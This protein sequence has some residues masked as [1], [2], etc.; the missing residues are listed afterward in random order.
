MSKGYTITVLSGYIF[1]VGNPLKAYS[2]LFT[3]VKNE[4]ELKGDKPTRTIAKLFLNSLYGKFASHYFVNASQVVFDNESLEVLEELYKIN[5]IIDLDVD[6]KVVNH[7]IQPKANAKVQKDI[8]RYSYEKSN[9]ALFDK[10]INMAIAATI[11]SHGRI[12]LYNLFIE[13]ERMG[14][15]VC[16]TDTDSVFA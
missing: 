11:T 13:V 3:A 10:N 7:C 14:G 4:S 2:E 1:K 15:K 9:K 8:L 6:M 12:L 5:S 16:Y